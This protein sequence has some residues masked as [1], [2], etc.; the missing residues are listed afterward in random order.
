MSETTPIESNQLIPSNKVREIPM[1]GW[2]S[3]DA[4]HSVLFTHGLGPCIGVTIF[5]PAS[6][7]ALWVI[8]QIPLSSPVP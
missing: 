8:S 5:D 3:T 6:K 1:K 7:K 2:G 4:A